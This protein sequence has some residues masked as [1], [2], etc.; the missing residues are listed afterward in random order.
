MTILDKMVF[1]INLNTVIQF[2]PEIGD[3]DPKNHTSNFAENPKQLW[4]NMF[5][6]I[7]SD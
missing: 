2:A 5:F 1:L 6:I 4:M 7:F 3:F